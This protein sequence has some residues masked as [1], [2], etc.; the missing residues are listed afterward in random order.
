MTPEQEVV[1]KKAH[2]M[3]RE[4]FPK[5]YGSIRFNLKPGKNQTNVNIEQS[6]QYP[7]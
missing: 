7:E 5:F 2:K 6:V 1:V 3:L 4:A